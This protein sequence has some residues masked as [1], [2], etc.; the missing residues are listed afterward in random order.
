[1]QRQA[2][3]LERVLLPEQEPQLLAL[4]REV[5]VHRLLVQVFRLSYSGWQRHFQTYII[6]M[7]PLGQHRPF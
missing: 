2:Q 3:L 7:R 5:A 1:L 4:Q 6:D